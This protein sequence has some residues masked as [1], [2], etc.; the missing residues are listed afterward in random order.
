M[1]KGLYLIVCDTQVAI[2]FWRHLVLTSAHKP[3]HNT[4]KHTH[5]ITVQNNSGQPDSL[6]SNGSVYTAV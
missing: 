6:E 2:E 1:F 4:H 3:E 5:T